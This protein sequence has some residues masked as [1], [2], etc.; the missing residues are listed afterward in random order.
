LVER[1]D[2]SSKAKQIL[3]GIIVRVFPPHRLLVKCK[4]YS[5]TCWGGVARMK[6]HLAGIKKNVI[7]CISVTDDVKDMFMKLL[8]DKEKVKEAN[9]QDCFEEV[10]IQ[11][12]KGT[13]ESF[14]RKGKQKTMNEMF[15]D[16]EL[17]ITDIC[18]CIYGNALP[19][20]LVR[21][22]LFIQMLKYVAEYGKWSNTSY[23]S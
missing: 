22:L 6:Y 10:D 2:E 4:Y 9:C 3:H 21:S 19:F 18:K 11:D 15:K 16:R 7:V 5:H 20:N 17:V 8:E 12:K 23:L 1:D 14:S 13:L